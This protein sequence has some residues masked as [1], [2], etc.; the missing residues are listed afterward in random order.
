MKY[1]RRALLS[2]G[3]GRRFKS[4]H[5]DQHFPNHL[6][7]LNRK[8]APASK[9]GLFLR[10]PYGSPGTNFGPFPAKPERSP[11]SA[12]SPCPATGPMLIGAGLGP[13]R[14]VP[15]TGGRVP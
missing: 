10:K 7:N 3:R 4:S 2:G 5:S 1:R 11:P 14:G 13:G 8:G 6:N 12:A 9:V 15:P